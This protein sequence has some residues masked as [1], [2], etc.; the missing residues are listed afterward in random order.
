[1]LILDIVISCRQP[2][3]CHNTKFIA[4][5]SDC[6]EHART[7]YRQTEPR[8]ATSNLLGLWD[9]SKNCVDCLKEPTWR[10]YAKNFLNAE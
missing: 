5:K 10:L 7:V 1:M 3:F 8:D 9:V 4:I 2:S 6:R